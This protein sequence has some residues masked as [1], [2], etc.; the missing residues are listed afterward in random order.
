M[1]KISFIVPLCLLLIVGCAGV[2]EQP[3][4]DTQHRSIEIFLSFNTENYPWLMGTRYPQ[5]AIWVRSGDETPET[6][7]VTQGAG[8]NKWWFASERPSALP[9]W[10]GIKK[11]EQDIRVDAVSGATPSGDVDTIFWKIPDKYRGKDISVFLEANV[12]IDYNDF[13]AKDENK[14]GYSDWNGQPS[15]VW[16]ASFTVDDQ[17]HEVKPEIVGH[18]HVL[19]SDNTIDPDTSHI[20][21][22]RYL[23]GYISVKYNPGM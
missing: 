15:V 9:V 14:P 13:Y 4:V 10:S 23:F 3:I 5:M 1:K 21:T 18:G 19:G 12:A 6:I 16:R 22:A 20:T 8:E 7:F 17:P 11:E 2:K